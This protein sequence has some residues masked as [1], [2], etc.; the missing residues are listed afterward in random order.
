MSE[1]PDRIVLKRHRD[2]VGRRHEAWIR[3]GLLLA[4]LGIPALAL[5]NVFGQRSDTSQAAS[6]S[7]ALAVHVPS[8]VRPGLVYE[9]RFRVTAVRSIEDARLVLDSNWLEGMTLNTIEPAPSEETSKNDDLELSLGE[10]PAGHT[11]RLLLQLQVNPTTIGHRSQDVAL[12]DGDRQ[13]VSL[14]RAMTVF[15]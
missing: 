4:L 15:P 12:F 10:I 13:L 7:G 11:F 8:Q 5:A 9:A 2:L 3:G 14:H 6:A 1:P